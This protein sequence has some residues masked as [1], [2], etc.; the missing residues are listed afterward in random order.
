MSTF[1]FCFYHDPCRS[2]D[3]WAAAMA[4][5][6]FTKGKVTLL[7]LNYN[8]DIPSIDYTDSTVYIVDITPNDIRPLFPI[9]QKVKELHIYDHHKGA[10]STLEH[11]QEYALANNLSHKLFIEFDENRLPYFER[12]SF[13]CFS[14]D[15][16][17]SAAVDSMEWFWVLSYLASLVDRVLRKNDILWN[18]ATKPDANNIIPSKRNRTRL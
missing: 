12:Y 6:N 7:G 3:G 10:G 18:Q 2:C 16:R 13:Q 9:L 15:L 11:L 8:Q 14:M 17:I 5:H 4:V 1:N